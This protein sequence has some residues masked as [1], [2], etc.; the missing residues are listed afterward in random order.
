MKKDINSLFPPEH[1]K[2]IRRLF[3]FLRTTPSQ[4]FFFFLNRH[5]TWPTV[6]NL[7]NEMWTRKLLKHYGEMTYV[8]S[9]KAGIL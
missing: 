6:L 8:N 9:Q 7:D 2:A 4:S 1:H 5:N 3:K